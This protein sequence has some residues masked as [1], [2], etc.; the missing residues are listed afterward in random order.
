MQS[1]CSVPAV[2]QSGLSQTAGRIAAAYPDSLLAMNK[3]LADAKDRRPPALHQ[4]VPPP[5]RPPG[6]QASSEARGRRRY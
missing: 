1:S 3:L 2:L 6:K 5:V 4:P